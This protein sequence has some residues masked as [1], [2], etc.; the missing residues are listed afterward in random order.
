MGTHM[1]HMPVPPSFWISLRCQVRVFSLLIFKIQ[2]LAFSR[3]SIAIYSARIVKIIPGTIFKAAYIGMAIRARDNQ[4]GISWRVLSK[5]L[6]RVHQMFHIV[7]SLAFTL[8]KRLQPPSLSLSEHICRGNTRLRST[9]RTQQH[10]TSA[11]AAMFCSTPFLA[12]LST[13]SLHSA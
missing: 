11:P 1:Y 3:L 6:V 12:Q 9:S 10:L 4:G 7:R 13:F 2:V 5:Q 8:N